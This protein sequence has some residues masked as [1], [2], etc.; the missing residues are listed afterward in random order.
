MATEAGELRN[1]GAY[2]H[3]LTKGHA[4]WFFNVSLPLGY[5]AID[6]RR[7]TMVPEEVSRD[8][9]AI[10]DEAMKLWAR[11]NLARPT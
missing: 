1:K 5:L 2:V 6:E 9:A 10:L 3:R 7:L 4:R 8:V 11:E